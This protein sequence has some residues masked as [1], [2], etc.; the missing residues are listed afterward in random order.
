MKNA[1]SLENCFMWLLLWLKTIVFLAI[2][3][4]PESLWEDGMTTETLFSP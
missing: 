4:V 3:V 1:S 2:K